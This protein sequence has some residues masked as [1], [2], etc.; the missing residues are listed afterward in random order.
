MTLPLYKNTM[1][2]IWKP[3]DKGG[4][5][6][7]LYEVSNLGRF[8]QLPRVLPTKQ[9]KGWRLTK[10]KIVIGTPRDGY[11]V[12]HMKKLGVRKQIDIHVLVARAFI[13]N[14]DNLP[15]VNHKNA[16][17]NDNRA[18]NLEWV[19]RQGN[20]QHALKMGLLKPVHG[21]K[22]RSAK[23]TEEQVIQIRYLYNSKQHSQTELSKMF[24]VNRYSI[25]DI[26]HRSSWK[27]VK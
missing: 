26:V 6:N 15:E 2:E 14:P 12:I 16:I 3:V 9:G 27:H 25:G 7:G 18:E 11:M 23:L 5:Y 10:E 8:K 13:P 22:H 17:R 19:T 4:Y 21:E 1:K 24:G 20:V